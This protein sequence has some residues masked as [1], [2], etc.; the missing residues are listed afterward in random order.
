MEDG[1]NI[2]GSP[3]H[4]TGLPKDQVQEV[5]RR[6]G[7]AVSEIGEFTYLSQGDTHRVLELEGPIKRPTL[8]YFVQTFA[9]VSMQY[10][11]HPEMLP[12]E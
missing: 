8:K 4:F 9:G 7:V 3:E 6:L 5:L 10:F 12:K 2:I 11:F 1:N